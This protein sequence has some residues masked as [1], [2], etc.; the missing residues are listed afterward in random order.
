MTSHA[1]GGRYP[2]LPGEIL[3]QVAEAVEEVVVV[4][5]EIVVVDVM[6]FDNALG[7]V[8]ISQSFKYRSSISRARKAVLGQYISR[9]MF[10]LLI[11]TDYIYLV[12]STYPAPVL[13]RSARHHVILFRPVSVN[14]KTNQ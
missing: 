5:E 13:R 14:E 3:R 4:D 2:F 12:I 7:I 8:E 10:S 9:E 6:I 1:S 11:R